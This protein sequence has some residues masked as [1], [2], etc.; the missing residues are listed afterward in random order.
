[1]N[2]KVIFLSQLSPVMLTG[3]CLKPLVTLILTV[4]HSLGPKKVL[5]KSSRFMR[6]SKCL[7]RDTCVVSKSVL[8]TAVINTVNKAT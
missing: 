4:G 7:S 6:N 2:I 5:Q 1:M 3:F 8:S